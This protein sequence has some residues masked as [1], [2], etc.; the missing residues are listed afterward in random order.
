MDKS[1][2]D[3][4]NKL[5]K[6]NEEELDSISGGYILDRGKG[7]A[8]AE[9]RYVLI[10]DSDGAVIHHSYSLS[11]LQKAARQHSDTFSDEVINRDQYEQIYGTPFQFF[12]DDLDD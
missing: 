2:S 5:N 8:Y 6:V 3:K 11:E 1:K 12:Y 7:V 10:R 4:P 9:E